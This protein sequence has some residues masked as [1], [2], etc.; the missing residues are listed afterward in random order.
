MA[1][2]AAIAALAASL[3]GAAGCAAG[4]RIVYSPDELRAT[5]ARRAPAVPPDERIVPYEIS[6]AHAAQARELV[7]GATTDADKVRMLVAAMFDPDV[8]GLHYADGA[9]GTAEETLA[10]RRGD[11]LALA[12]VFV[13][14]ARAVGVPAQFL[15]ASVRIHETL[16]LDDETSV[17]FGH[18][19]AMV[20]TGVG[21][22]G[23]DFAQLGTIVWW[24]VIDDPEALAH[25]YNNRGYALLQGARSEGAAVDWVGAARQFELAVA[26][27]PGFA[28]GWNN[29]GIAAAHLGRPD[30]ASADYRRAIE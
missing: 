20:D 10:S 9:V 28:R 18:V 21:K 2:R 26:V 5:I 12:S 25:F 23:L 4:E 24:R 1:C 8:F 7:T 17:H 14:L 15:D 16:Y 27:K 6:E 13:G 30:E 11:C 19:T 29:L 3:A 22:V